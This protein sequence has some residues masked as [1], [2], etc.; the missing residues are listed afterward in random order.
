M[1][2][3]PGATTQPPASS[4]SSPRSFGPIS[5]MTPSEIATSASRPGVP[6]PSTT[7]P[8]RITRSAI[9]TPLAC[10]VAIAPAGSPGGGSAVDREHD[11]GDLGGAIAGEVQRGVGDVARRSHALEGLHGPHDGRL[12]E[13]RVDGGG[14]V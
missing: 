3:K 11:P 10:E 7:V 9:G 2:M 8:P 1:S 14:D 12:V 6:L 5:R 4:S 13:R